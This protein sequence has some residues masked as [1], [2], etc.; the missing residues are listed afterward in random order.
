MFR[1]KSKE[2]IS[3]HWYWLIPTNVAFDITNITNGNAHYQ[4]LLVGTAGPLI[5]PF[6]ALDTVRGRKTNW[7]A[8][9]QK[10]LR[11]FAGCHHFH[12]ETRRLNLVVTEKTLQNKNL[13]GRIQL[14]G[15]SGIQRPG[16]PPEPLLQSDTYTGFWLILNWTPPLFH[17]TKVPLCHLS[18]QLPSD[19]LSSPGRSIKPEV[20]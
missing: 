11:N 12:K 17:P 2:S 16:A 20:S 14:R 5:A 9:Q 8:C 18:P 4:L 19:P 6:Q 10:W 15:E 7:I 3:L 1:H 13:P